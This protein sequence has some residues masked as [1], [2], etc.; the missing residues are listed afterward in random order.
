MYN[1]NMAIANV[2]MGMRTT[3]P[4]EC[5]PA[6]DSPAT[7]PSNSPFASKL[8]TLLSEPVTRKRT[9]PA[10]K[11]SA[12][13]DRAHLTKKPSISTTPN[14][15]RK[16][17]KITD[18]SQDDEPPPYQKH[19]ATLSDAVDP[20]IL[21]RSKRKLEEK[22]RLYTSMKRGTHIPPSNSAV[23]SNVL[24]DFDR[25]WAE[26]VEAGRPT[27]QD[28]SS[29]SDHGDDSAEE[30]VDYE[31]EFGRA[32]RGTRAQAER[33]RRHL[34]AQKHAASELAQASA[35]PAPPSKIIRGDV[36]QAAAFNPDNTIAMQMDELARKRDRSMTP[37]PAVHYDA[38]S[39]V[40][41]KGVGFYA[42][43]RDEKT[44]QREMAGLEGMRDSTER[45]RK[46]REERA[47]KRRVM[48]EERK[49]VIRAKKE[50][51]L[52]ERFLD[53]LDGV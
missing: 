22:A 44:R 2:L 4:H 32:R 47:E 52:A 6:R 17:R 33:E 35:R 42:F 28:S 34:A 37:P 23:E 49:K 45:E 30:L 25:K 53:G 40:R 18:I 26:D 19:S 8:N 50:A 27:E 51:K 39:E 46:E 20:S 10:Y 11:S 3:V 31:D 38:N 12:N 7:N 24:V 21:D 5:Q 1:N 14:K 9:D 15:K 41:S 16:K 29:D 48:L 36:I 43:S 13:V